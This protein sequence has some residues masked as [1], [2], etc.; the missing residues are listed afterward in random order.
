MRGCKGLAALARVCKGRRPFAHLSRVFFRRVIPIRSMRQAQSRPIPT[1]Q[2]EHV[3]AMS[4]YLEQ[5]TESSCP[6]PKRRSR[7]PRRAG[8]AMHRHG[9]PSRNRRN[10]LL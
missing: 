7:P 9:Q 2:V 8:G 6:D 3:I 4:G 10:L 5:A 1:E